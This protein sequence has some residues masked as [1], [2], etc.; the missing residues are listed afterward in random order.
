MYKTTKTDG[1]HPLEDPGTALDAE[2]GGLSGGPT[3]EYLAAER[4]RAEADPI[5]VDTVDLTYNAEPD[6]TDHEV[7]TKDLHPMEVPRHDR[8]AD[9]N[10]PEPTPERVIPGGVTNAHPDYS[11]D[12]DGVPGPPASGMTTAASLS[13][14]GYTEPSKPEPETDDLLPAGNAS[15]EEWR[16]YAIAQGTDPET[17]A[18]MSRN[19]LR[20]FY[21]EEV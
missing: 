14:T 7:D 5:G 10:T 8:Y 13:T 20:D 21:T 18:A 2:H 6:P 15:A 3:E 19:E 9:E 16:A 11:V 1:E 4:A 12:A 17:A